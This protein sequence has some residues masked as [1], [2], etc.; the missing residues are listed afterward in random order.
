M[1]H[2]RERLLLEGSSISV[3]LDEL[4]DIEKLVACEQLTKELENEAADDSVLTLEEVAQYLTRAR[5]CNLPQENKHVRMLEARQRA[6]QSWGERARHVLLQPPENDGTTPL[7]RGRGFGL[8]GEERR[9][10]L[11]TLRCLSGD[12]TIA[13]TA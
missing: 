11:V 4:M 12:Y 1:E 6:G 2:D 5:A 8:H 3:F 9:V 10:F 13:T 7:G